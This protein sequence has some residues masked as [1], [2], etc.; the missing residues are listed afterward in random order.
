MAEA[1]A[2]RDLALASHPVCRDAD[3]EQQGFLIGEL[4]TVVTRAGIRIGGKTSRQTLGTAINLAQDLFEW[5]E[6]GRWRWIEPKIPKGPGLSGRALAEEAYLVATLHDPDRN[7]LHYEA[8][9]RLLIEE[10]VVIKGTNPGHTTYSALSNAKQWFEWVSSG[11][12]RWK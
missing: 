10:R 6:G 11:T 1:L 5:V 4:E 9:K 8:I 3:P 7:G 2:G 12:F